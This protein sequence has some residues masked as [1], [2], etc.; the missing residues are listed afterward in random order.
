MHAV[1]GIQVCN[2][3]TKS[4][5]K[6]L[7]LPTIYTQNQLPIDTSEVATPKKL[8]K[9][10]YLELVLGEICERDDIQMDLQI[11]S[12]CVKALEPIKVISSEA[13]GLHAYETVLGW[14]IVGPMNV[15]PT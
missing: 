4:K 8:E 12:N 15:K 9:W 14:C 7:I 11:V 13:Q 10:K 2:P 5:K 3:D 1:D 6:G